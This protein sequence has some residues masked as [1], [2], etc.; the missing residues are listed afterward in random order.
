MT[1]N[2]LRWERTTSF[3]DYPFRELY[4]VTYADADNVWAVGEGGLIL[5]SDDGGIT[6]EDRSLSTWEDKTQI[7]IYGTDV[8]LNR[9]LFTD[10]QNG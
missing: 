4:S 9:V 7:D 8:I 2:E 5:H 6:W 10:P 1:E 3:R